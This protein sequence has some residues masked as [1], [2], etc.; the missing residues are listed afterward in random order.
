MDLGKQRRMINVVPTDVTVA[1]AEPALTLTPE[2]ARELLGD[3]AV[4]E[5][6]V[7]SADLAKLGQAR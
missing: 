3:D 7:A 6:A 5:E 1:P 4:L 2:V